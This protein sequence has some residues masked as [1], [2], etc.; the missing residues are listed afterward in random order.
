[1]VELWL[2]LKSQAGINWW[3]FI[4]WTALAFKLGRIIEQEMWL[5]AHWD[6]QD[7]DF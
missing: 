4:V 7:D 5:M 1:M 2:V 3:Q 6:D